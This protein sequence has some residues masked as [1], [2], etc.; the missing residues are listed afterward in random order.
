MAKR[1]PREPGVPSHRGKQPNLFGGWEASL[2][3]AWN[4]CS[5]RG[6][7]RQTH[8]GRWTSPFGGRN[9]NTTRSAAQSLR[10]PEGKPHRGRH[11]SLLGDRNA[12]LTGTVAVIQGS[13]KPPSS[14]SEDQPLRRPE[15]QPHRGRPANPFGVRKV[16]LIGVGP[17]VPSGAGRPA[18]S[19]AVAQFQRISVHQ[20]YRGARSPSFF[21]SRETTLTRFGCSPSS[22]VGPRAEDRPSASAGDE[23]RSTGFGR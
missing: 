6:A 13:G 7:W 10:R 2:I 5:P 14:G 18:S 9:S 20:P 4:S 1:F 16:S 23:R 11:P 15:S 19:R 22:E 17:K 21:G 12:S 3:E 8:R